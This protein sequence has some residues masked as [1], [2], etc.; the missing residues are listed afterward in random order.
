MDGVL[1][2]VPHRHCV[3]AH[4]PMHPCA[5]APMRVCACLVEPVGAVGGADHEDPAALGGD[6]VPGREKL[7]DLFRVWV[8]VKL[9]LGL[10]SGL[11]LELEVEEGVH[12]RL[13][14][15]CAVAANHLEL[16]TP[17]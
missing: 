5:H 6:A 16:L 8:R 3:H 2:H 13:A 15:P 9:G 1:L 10:G 7:V 11:G 17:G 12:L 4:E 14:A